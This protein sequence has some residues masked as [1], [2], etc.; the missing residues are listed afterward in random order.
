MIKEQDDRVTHKVDRKKMHIDQTLHLNS[1]H[2]PSQKMGVL[3]T[4]ITTAMR[5]TDNDHIEQEKEHLRKVF[6]S[7]GYTISQINKVSMK[8]K[9]QQRR[10]R[11]S[12]N[13]NNVEE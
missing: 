4:L 3:N 11:G 13:E 2:H 7:N 9:R 1:H 10:N 12:T 5:I 6:V 8:V